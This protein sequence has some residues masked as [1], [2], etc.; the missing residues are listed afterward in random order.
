L[1]IPV[2]RWYSIPVR[3]D[4]RGTQSDRERGLYATAFDVTGTRR[5]YRYIRDDRVFEVGRGQGHAGG[6]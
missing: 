2:D 5:D 6:E 3:R 4:D 1:G